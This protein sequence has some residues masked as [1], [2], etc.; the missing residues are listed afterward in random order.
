MASKYTTNYNL[1]QWEASD[2][3]LRTEFNADN[4]KIDAALAGLNS[5]KA[6][7]T[8]LN[9]LKTTV[10]AKASQ[11]ALDALSATVSGHT[12]SLAKKGNVQLYTLS[13]TGNG[14]FSEPKSLTFPKEPW[15]IFIGGAN[16]YMIIVRGVT[17]SAT[18]LDYQLY[19]NSVIWSGKTVS[20]RHGGAGQ[21]HGMMNANGTTYQVIALLQAD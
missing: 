19:Q 2:K 9:S 18:T 3:V 15:V 10:N 13:Y 16:S 20:W 14:I 11:S 8:A 7:K 17:Y 1:C 4:A 5:G 12:A 6:D 21:A